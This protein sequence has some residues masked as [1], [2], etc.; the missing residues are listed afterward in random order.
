MTPHD[1]PPTAAQAACE[2]NFH[3]WRFVPETARYQSRDCPMC[4]RV[5]HRQTPGWHRY[6]APFEHAELGL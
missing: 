2:H 5:Q 3:E 4:G 1:T 6:G